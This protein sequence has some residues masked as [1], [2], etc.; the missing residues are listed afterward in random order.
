VFWCGRAIISPLTAGKVGRHLP[1][2]EWKG[3]AARA[4]GGDGTRPVVLRVYWMIPVEV[5]MGVAAELVV[6][7]TMMDLVAMSDARDGV[8]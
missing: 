4:C 7:T 6:W 5:M 3:G 1:S 8:D 2:E